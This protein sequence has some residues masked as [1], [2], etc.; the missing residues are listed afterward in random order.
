MKTYEDRLSAI[1]EKT[2]RQKQRRR[3][4]T[5][6]LCTSCCLLLAVSTALILL[7][8]P[9][10]LPPLQSSSSSETDRAT[11]AETIST[12]TTASSAATLTETTAVEVSASPSSAPP[13]SA[14]TTAASSAFASTTGM[15]SSSVSG[16]S[17]TRW[18]GPPVDHYEE[19]PMSTIADYFGRDFRKL[20]VP[21]GLTYYS[22]DTQNVMPIYFGADGQIIRDVVRFT[23]ADPVDAPACSDQAR[24]VT[25]FVGKVSAPADYRY[26][27]GEDVT[28]HGTAVHR[29][30]FEPVGE[31]Y[32]AQYAIFSAGG[33]QYQLDGGRLTAAEF[34]RVLDD[35]LTGNQ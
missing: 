9:Q 20:A 14:A 11:T 10:D 8:R 33:L 5:T 31:V 19:W 22:T 3:Q 4:R 17:P 23:F 30:R 28:V 25:L 21:A 15:S 24:T 34:D 18:E 16:H 6:L 12:Q 27:Q 13:S 26:P 32:H 35:L 2:S 1:L 7:Q 29:L